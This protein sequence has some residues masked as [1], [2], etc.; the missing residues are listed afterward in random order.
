[1]HQYRD[2]LE[3]ALFWLDFLR[4]VEDTDARIE[5]LHRPTVEHC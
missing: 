2:T 3:S 4:H 1:M 5:T